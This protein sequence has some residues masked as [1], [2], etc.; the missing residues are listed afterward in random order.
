[1]V[2]NKS[3]SSFVEKSVTSKISQFSS[4]SSTHDVFLEGVD[5]VD[6]SFVDDSIPPAIPQKTRSRRGRHERQPSPYDNVPDNMG[7]YFTL[8]K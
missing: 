5:S 7:K 8:L 6:C 3:D 1:M 4:L 2:E